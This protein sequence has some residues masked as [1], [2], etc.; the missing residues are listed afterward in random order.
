[1]SHSLIGRDDRLVS[2]RLRGREQGSILETLK[3]GVP[4]GVTL[5]PL[6]RKAQSFVDALV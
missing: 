2:C 6:E 4:G 5:V 3:A 1:M